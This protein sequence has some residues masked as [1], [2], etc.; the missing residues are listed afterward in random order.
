MVYLVFWSFSPTLLQY[1]S[2]TNA[3][4]AIKYQ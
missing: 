3:Y 4:K 1:L 2:H